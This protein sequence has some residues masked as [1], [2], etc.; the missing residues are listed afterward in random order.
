[1]RSLTTVFATLALGVWRAHVAPY[2]SMKLLTGG[3]QD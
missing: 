1:M 2:V 3:T